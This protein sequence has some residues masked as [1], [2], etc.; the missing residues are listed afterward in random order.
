M[1]KQRQ[2]FICVEQG[3]QILARGLNVARHSVFSGPGKHSGNT[4]KSEI[5]SN[6]SQ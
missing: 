4:F 6:L 1:N 3:G 5:S 2:S